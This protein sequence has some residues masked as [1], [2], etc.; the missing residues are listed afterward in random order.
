MISSL[1]PW[2]FQIKENFTMRGWR[3]Q[4][5]NKP[6]LHFLHGNGF[7]G[8]T[9]SPMLQS[10]MDDFDLIL[11]D[12]PGHGDSDSGGAFMGWNRCA[13]YCLNIMGHFSQQI[14]P[15]VPRYAL[16]HSFGGVITALM[17][18][19]DQRRFAKA[20]L[21]DPVIFSPGMLRVMAAA[22]LVGLL[23]NAPMAK[24]ARGRKNTWP[25]RTAAYES[26]VGRGIFK[27]WSDDSLQAYVDYA[28]A[29][30]T[31]GVVLKCQPEREADIFSSY[32]KKLW[33]YLKDVKTP[34]RIQMAED[35]F[36][37][38]ARSVERLVQQPAYSAETVAGGHCFMME[39]PK[40]SAERVK[41]YLLAN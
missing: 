18:G 29:D 3:T 26:F 14:S 22:D 28:L 20:V 2:S 21:M 12:L 33:S 36:P 37:F 16:G 10:L 23:Q 24:Q 27:T 9:Y 39:D 19:K 41:Q 34:T 35:S 38:I 32:P 17:M 6:V 31:T 8:L 1:E 30:H 7:S 4:W 11:T 40:A 25:D 15:T 5:R 13:D